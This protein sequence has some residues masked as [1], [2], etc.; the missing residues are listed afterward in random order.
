MAAELTALVQRL[1]N[2]TSRL[3]SVSIG[4]G[5]KTSSS[6]VDNSVV[7]PFVQHFDTLI[8]NGSL[9]AFKKHCDKVGGDIQKLCALVVQAFKEEREFLRKVSICSKPNDVSK[10]LEPLSK[11]ISEV[12]DFKEKNRGSK[13]INH[14]NCVTEAIPALG[15]VTVAPTPKPYAKEMADAAIFWGNRILKDFKE[16]DKSQ[17]E[18]VKAWYKVLQDI[19]DYIQEN[20]TT[21]I[22][23]KKNGM[24]ISALGG[25]SSGGPPPPPPPPPVMLMEPTSG[26]DGDDSTN[27]LFA[28]LNKGSDIT[29]S[30]KKVTKDMQTHKN[31]NL[32]GNQPVKDTSNTSS[33]KVAA[34]PAKCQLVGKKWE[35]ENYVGN[36]SIEVNVTESK[37]SV[38]IFKCIDSVIVVKGKVNNIVLDNCKKCG[39]CFESAISSV[40]IV[41]SQSIKVQVTGSVPTV[42]IDKTDGCQVY[43]SAEAIN[44]DIV[45]AKSSE[46]NII[47]PDPKN[48]DGDFKEIPLPEQFKTKFDGT[49]MVTVPADL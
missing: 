22:V 24:D 47:I 5:A 30:L 8:I 14:I 16:K 9:D 49:K 29:K 26:G 1:E 35:V 41:N 20:F 33:T 37:Q 46:M 13:Q 11:K 38:Y 7:D 10:I 45:T 18:L 15:W 6:G 2:V 27:A 44:A 32:R 36:Q 43:L 3:E 23:W 21:G 34:K 25:A 42:S 40:D 12:Q 39:V 48:K 4:D 17:G 31:P 28:E 19:Q